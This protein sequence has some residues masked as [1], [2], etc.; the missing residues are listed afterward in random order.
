MKT[1]IDHGVEQMLKRKRIRF[2]CSAVLATTLVLLAISLGTAK[3]GV[4]IFGTGLGADYAAFYVAGKILNE[5]SAA[6]LYDLGLQNQIQHSLMP[7]LPAGAWLPFRGYPPLVA[8]CFQPLALL[9]YEWSYP[10][11][12]VISAG[13]YVAGFTLIWRTL[14]A[15]PSRERSTALLLALSFEPF[16]MES[17]VGG[18]LPAVGFFFIALALFCED[19][20]HSILAGVALAFCLYK[21]TLVLLILP[22]LLIGRRLKTLLGFC[23]AAGA[24]VTIGVLLTGPRSYLQ[25]VDMLTTHLRDTTQRASVFADWKFVD[26]VSFV[27]L[28][29]GHTSMLGRIVVLLLCC[30][31]FLCL[32]VGWWRSKNHDGDRERLLWAAT[33]TGTLVV[34]VYVGIYDATLVVLSALLTADVLLRRVQFTSGFRLLLL[35][36]YLVPWFSQFI[37]QATGVQLYTLVLAGF[38]LYQLRLCAT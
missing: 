26:L 19:R 21:P 23:A 30:A 37:A 20:R 29:V 10:A 12:L 9:R 31:V 14:H 7:G 11:W 13:L 5:C 3:N 33:L 2:V 1:W 35:L 17:W 25:Y 28:L 4:T 27:R 24:L 36:L 34:N 18:Q 32:A 38:A 16:L 8:V 6:Q 15:T 22:L